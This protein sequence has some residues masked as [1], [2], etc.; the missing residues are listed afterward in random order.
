MNTTNNELTKDLN[1]HELMLLELANE[2]WCINMMNMTTVTPTT[3]TDESHMMHCM[4]VGQDLYE[5][6][7]KL[8][9]LTNEELTM[10]NLTNQE[11]M[12]MMNANELNKSALVSTMAAEL[13]HN[14]L[15]PQISLITSAS[16][17]GAVDYI[18]DMGLFMEFFI[19]G[20]NI[21]E[22]TIKD[23]EL[24]EDLDGDAIVAA[25]VA[26]KYLTIVEDEPEM[27]TRLYEIC[28][29]RTEAYAPALASDG[30]DRRFGYAPVVY[31]ELF[32]EA[33]EAL[34]S[35]EYTVD[36]DMLSLALR[37]QAKMGGH[38][39]DAEG[40]VLKGCQK[41]DSE[42]A[43]VSEFKGDRRGRMYQAACHGPNGQ[44]SDRSRALMNLVGVPTDYNI[45]EVRA[46]ILDEV[47]DMVPN[48]QDAIDTLKELGEENFIIWCIDTA[49]TKKPWSFV[50]ASR[51]MQALQR[52][53]RPYIGMAVGLDAKCSGPQL[54]ALMA[55]DTRIAAACGFTM[56]ELD[57]AYALA[58]IELE[59]AGFHGLKRND[60]KKPYM[61]VFYGQGW[62]A[63]TN[64]ESLGEEC[65]NIMYGNQPANDDT[66]KA[67]HKAIMASFGVK[68]N[69]VRSLIKSYG[70]ITTGRTKHFM[71]DGFEVAMNYKHKVNVLGEMMDYETEAHD[72]YVRN[73]AEQYK[74]INFQLRTKHTHVGDFARNGFVNM[75]QATDGLLARLIVVH[76]KRLGAKHI[77]AVHD[78]FR[79]NVTELHI[80]ETAIKSAYQDLFGNGKVHT[81]DDLPHGTDI[82]NL[83]FEGANQQLVEDAE[84][85]TI[86]Q[87]TST[88]RRYLQKI[89]GMYVNELIG[90]LG[91]GAYYFAK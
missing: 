91:E 42:H 31:S 23:Q 43:Y 14:G 74:F 13:Y 73:N 45:K 19:E 58:I 54:G 75:I 44:A 84:P 35:T 1:D 85:K 68:M 18:D 6:R 24:E 56:V 52:G 82:L 12:N 33:I 47:R 10:T 32:V 51:I 50:K 87:F 41:M 40:Y 36:D 17:M 72:V 65:W 34:E 3:Y 27:G 53:E 78:C 8:S 90:K 70:T 77:I 48:V 83:Y 46:I 21:T 11:V 29:L 88:G 30:V 20:L 22:V 60:I 9:N 61:G 26:S 5:E 69:A 39:D 64:P 57:D 28:Q 81:S 76:L 62:A 71:P 55:G 2:H 63:F 37:V 59:K 86:S 15:S 80:L 89:N 67:F 7:T 4:E 25:L 79:V 38:E 16:F 66:A 49:W